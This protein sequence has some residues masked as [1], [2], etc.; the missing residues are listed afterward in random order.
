MRTYITCTRR[1]GKPRV[2]IDVC[3]ACRHRL[4]CIPFNRYRRP[5]MFPD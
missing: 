4:K 5:Q 2:A 1:K 3:R